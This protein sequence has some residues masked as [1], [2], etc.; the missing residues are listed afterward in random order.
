[1]LVSVS[2]MVEQLNALPRQLK[3][4]SSPLGN[5]Q[6]FLGAS[7]P[8]ITPPKENSTIMVL[9]REREMTFCSITKA[10]Q[11]AALSLA[12]QELMML[13]TQRHCDTCSLHQHSRSGKLVSLLPGDKATGSLRNG[14]DL[15]LSRQTRC[16]P[17]HV[18]L[19]NTQQKVVDE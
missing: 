7:Q 6:R 10:Y 12:I 18:T 17:H 4:S 15:S 5:N 14:P 8:A 2:A 19:Q 3:L 9:Q 13:V 11:T 16:P 1:M